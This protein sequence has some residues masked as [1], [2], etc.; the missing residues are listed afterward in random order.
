[1]LPAH[2]KVGELRQW[3]NSHA[4]HADHQGY[5]VVDE[6]ERL[7]G[8]VTRRDV[9]NPVVQADAP[10]SSL[11]VRPPIAVC[12]NDTLREAADHMVAE[13]VGRL[14]VVDKSRPDQVLGILTRGDLLASQA[15]QVRQDRER[16]RH[17]SFTKRGA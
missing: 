7:C 17:W 10:L 12:L 16:Q 5:P 2:A 4:P 8:V 3:M 11:L 15:G 1:M 13:N 9:F 14:V 6:A